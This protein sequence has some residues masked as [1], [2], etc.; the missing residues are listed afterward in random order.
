MRR[1][2]LRFF[3][4]ATWDNLDSEAAWPELRAT[5]DQP[6]NSQDL[7]L[8]HLAEEADRLARPRATLVRLT[9]RSE[10]RSPDF[11]DAA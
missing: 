4:D 10:P 7:G 8:W 9:P 2:K 6:A 3:E 5:L 11:P 1:N